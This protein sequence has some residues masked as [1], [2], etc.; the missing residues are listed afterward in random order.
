MEETRLS[1]AEFQRAMADLAASPA[2]CGAAQVDPI[3]A[4]SSYMLSTRESARIASVVHQPGMAVHCTIHRTT[5]LLPLDTLLPLTC[6]AL[7]RALGREV[8]AYW[9]VARRPAIRFEI[10]AARFVACLERRL[11]DASI[12]WPW[13]ATALSDLAR[14]ELAIETLRVAPRIATDA[15]PPADPVRYRLDPAARVVALS[16]DAHALLTGA[17]GNPPDLATIP[18]RS[19]LVVITS[20]AG[21]LDVFAVPP[22]RADDVEALVHSGIAVKWLIEVGLAVAS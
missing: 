22:E 11:A 21:R 3:R 2:L 9:A 19:C 17:R 12:T 7:G 10:E 13:P 20:E 6:V 18:R 14:L 8:D 4:L 5:R 16:H 15:S 1:L